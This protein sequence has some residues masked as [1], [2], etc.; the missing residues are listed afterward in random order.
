MGRGAMVGCVVSLGKSYGPSWK[1]VLAG[2]RVMTDS[3]HRSLY[4]ILT[5]RSQ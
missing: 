5:E 4:L 1:V 2:A 3:M